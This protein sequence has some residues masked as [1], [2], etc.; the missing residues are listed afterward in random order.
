MDFLFSPW[1]YNYI[2]AS[3]PADGCVFCTRAP[4]RES[5]CEQDERNLILYRGPR[6]FVIANAFPYTTGHIMVVP[7]RHV[8]QLQR[9][10]AAEATELIAL[11]QRLEG[12]LRRL[13]KPDGLNLG[14]NLGKAAGAGVAGHLHL[15][16]LPRWEGDANFMTAIGETRVVPEALEIT[17]QRIRQALAE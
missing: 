4:A 1:R 12:V 2:T 17:A 13:Y 7:Y 10:E 16:M 8:D 15:H 5:R 3:A 11:A 14:M 9:L 6:C